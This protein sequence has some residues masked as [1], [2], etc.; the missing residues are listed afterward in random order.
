MLLQELLSEEDVEAGVSLVGNVDD[1]GIFSLNFLAL[2]SLISGNE[3]LYMTAV[4]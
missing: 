3:S 4:I 1:V 2:H